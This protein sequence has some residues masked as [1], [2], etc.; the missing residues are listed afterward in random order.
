[1][2]LEDGTHVLFDDGKISK[3]F[4]SSGDEVATYTYLKE[5]GIVQGLQVSRSG[6][7]F[8]YDQMGFLDSITAIDGTINRVVQ[9]T[10]GDG[11][12]SDD[13]IIQLILQTADGNKLT[14][15]E[16]DAEGNI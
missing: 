5:N 2:R 6:N 7:Q 15:F 1:M 16:L 9:D 11:V 3:V 8:T 4:N 10:N 13:E 14:D 12:L